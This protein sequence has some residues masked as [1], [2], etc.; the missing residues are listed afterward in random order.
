MNECPPKK[1]PFQKDMSSSNL[2]FS[3]DMLVLFS[4][5]V[6]KNKRTN[7]Q[8]KTNNMYGT[9]CI[10]LYN[11]ESEIFCNHPNLVGGFN[12]VEKH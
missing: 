3:R 2:W 6:N 11:P 10:F 9:M 4:R 1:G 5:G 12:L 8:T 7:Q